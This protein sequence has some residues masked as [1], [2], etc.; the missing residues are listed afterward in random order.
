MIKTRQL[1][2]LLACLLVMGLTTK[3]TAAWPPG[4]G[5]I[6]QAS[7]E[8]AKFKKQSGFPHGRRGY[9]ID[10][11]VPPKHG[12]AVK[13]YNMQWLPKS[14]SKMKRKSK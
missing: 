6:F 12:G 2:L 5:K 9:V 8:K 13:A 1:L 14:E 10:Y 4:L 7:S 11:I 3:A